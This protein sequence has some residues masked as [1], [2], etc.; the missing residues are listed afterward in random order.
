M[1][2]IGDRGAEC[3]VT[4]PLKSRPAPHTGDYWIS[5]DSL[6]PVVKLLES[7]YKTL[8]FRIPRAGDGS[9]TSRLS[10]QTIGEGIFPLAAASAGG[11]FA[12]RYARNSSH[13]SADVAP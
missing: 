6:S 12:W 1:R 2:K 13:R 5:P 11:S 4:V 10:R 3:E 9:L 7:D 8:P